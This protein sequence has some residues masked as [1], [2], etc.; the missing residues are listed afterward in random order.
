[1]T[2]KMEVESYCF[3][4]CTW[5]SSECADLSDELTLYLQEVQ[6]SAGG[7]TET[8]PDDVLAYS[9]QLTGLIVDTLKTD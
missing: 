7:V 6:T 5:G 1:M 8:I 9:P 4:R 3:R 2:W